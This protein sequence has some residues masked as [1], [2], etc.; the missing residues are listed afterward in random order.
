MTATIKKRRVK[1]KTRAYDI[2]QHTHLYAAWAAS[3]G[4]SVMGC[5][6]SV[7]DGRALLESIGF[8]RSINRPSKLPPVRAMD[9][10]HRR[11]RTAMIKASQSAFTHG[12]AAKLINLYLKCR[13]VCGGWHEDPRVRQLH[14]PIDDVMLKVL[15]Q[16]N[17]GGFVDQ[18]RALRRQR[19]SKFDSVHYEHAI[20][21][22]RRS[23]DGDPLWKIEEMWQGNQ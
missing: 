7:A 12:V 13:F 15:I 1:Q 10:Q 20:E 14:P 3:R 6:F 18:W 23:L 11:W 16:K 2:H 21:L 8:D 22:I 4:A 19:W 5:R 9:R 17:V